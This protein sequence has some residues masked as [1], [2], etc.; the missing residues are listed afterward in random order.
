ME[1]IKYYIY[2]IRGLWMDRY[3]IG[4]YIADLKDLIK[5]FATYYGND[6]E[7]IIFEVKVDKK[8]AMTIESKVHSFLKD[9][10]CDNELYEVSCLNKFLQICS[11]LCENYVD[12][13]LI[14]NTPKKKKEKTPNMVDNISINEPIGS[15]K[16]KD[17]IKNI[18]RERYTDVKEVDCYNTDPNILPC[19]NGDIILKTGELIESKNEYFKLKTNYNGINNS[20]LSVDKLM[21]DLFNEDTQTIEYIQRL[22]GYGL[23]GK[24]P[25]HILAIFHGKGSNGK[26]LLMNLIER[27]MG[28][29]FVYIK[30][31]VFYKTYKRVRSDSHI[32]I[33]RNKRYIC[34]SDSEEVPIFDTD[35]FKT[36]TGG[37]K[38]TVR[39]SYAKDHIT[40][41]ATFLPILL[42]NKTPIF[43]L[44]D[45]ALMR[46]VIVIPFDNTYTNDLS[47]AIPLNKNDSSHKL[48][49]INLFEKLSTVNFMEELLIWLV[50]GCVKW[51]KSGFGKLSD[52]ILHSINNYTSDVK[53]VE[54]FIEKYCDKDEKSSINDSEFIQEIKKK[55]HI[56]CLT[57][58]DLSEK[59][60]NLGFKYINSHGRKYKGLKWKN[61]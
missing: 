48:K 3:K 12:F 57:Q 4:Y 43:D 34:K 8:G 10:H 56:H 31:E 11:E 44:N 55:F 30:P 7:V 22:L 6:L 39:D 54:N 23:I 58:K 2:G 13:P 35:N 53:Y 40:F 32:A 28:S 25:E 15:L 9:Y 50:R 1:Y 60:R 52:N 38:I 17:N 24:N 16:N 41:S 47:Y 45:I 5:R 18:V 42:C 61:N 36:L 51:H 14:R 49:D 27:L 26:S 37:N 21:N 29:F 59:M 19:K 20:T 33:L 46:R